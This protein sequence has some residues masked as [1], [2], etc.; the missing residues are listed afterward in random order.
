MTERVST[1]CTKIN[2]MWVTVIMVF[3][4][5][6]CSYNVRVCPSI[7]IT[8]M[9][10]QHEESLND[11]IGAGQCPDYN[12][13]DAP[14]PTSS[15]TT[16][17]STTP[18]FAEHPNIGEGGVYDWD[19]A[20]QGIILSSFFWGYVLTHIP[21]GM[22][23]DRFGAKRI[24]GISTFVSGLFT[25][26]IPAALKMGGGASVLIC[27][28]I[29][30]GLAQGF[31]YPALNVML[32]GWVPAKHKSTVA[33]IVYAGAPLGTVA[34]MGTSG[35]LLAY[36]APDR[37]GWE[38]V[39]YLFGSM[40]LLW[41][42]VWFP[43]C[44]DEPL[45]H[46]FMDEQEA[47][48]LSAELSAHKHKKPPQ[49][50]WRHIIR[51]KPVWALVAASVG[52]GWGF[53]T[54][55]N[56]MP[57]YM[58]SVMRFP[59][60]HNGLLSAVPYFGMAISSIMWAKFADFLEY[61]N[62][63][64]RT[65]IHKLGNTVATIGPAIC[66]IVAAQSG[67]NRVVSV[68]ALIVGVTCMGAALPSIKINVIDLSPNY[69]GFIMALANGLTGVTGM[70][71]PYVV[72]LLTPNQSA[73]EWSRVFYTISAVLTITNSI[74]VMWGSAEVQFWN[75]PG[76]HLKE[77]IEREKAEAA[78][79]AKESVELLQMQSEIV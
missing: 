61:N 31:A 64:S 34:A 23:A 75:E 45:E 35:P 28:R 42:L 1:C 19:E 36:F 77:K 2:Q 11:T 26:L 38:I 73:E 6:F 56:D 51:S 55:V 7:A 15:N 4:C 25:L 72:G 30:T 67:C 46:P 20:I 41:C 14:P 13:V 9:V 32:S 16:L 54:M 62:Y 66:T 79:A 78:E 39:Y 69:S 37:I 74:Y 27:F 60:G 52:H 12:L 49:V 58:K 76:F 70:L 63:M 33:A 47:K 65:K 18:T 53:L 59:I 3:L 10:I 5:L 24:L 17:N 68:S 44:Y 22:L 8:Q 21:A 57:K 29:V 48:N 43:L 40:S 71:A 50:P